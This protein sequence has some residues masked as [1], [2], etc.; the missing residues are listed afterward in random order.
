LAIP[1]MYSHAGCIRHANTQLHHQMKLHIY[2]NSGSAKQGYIL[3]ESQTLSIRTW[4][5]HGSFVF[6][7]AAP[8]CECLSYCEGWHS[9]VMFELMT[10]CFILS[11]NVLSQVQ[12][13]EP[14]PSLINPSKTLP[15]PVLSQ[16]TPLT[17][18][19]TGLGS[20]SPQGSAW[21]CWGK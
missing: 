3:L 17:V 8:R 2:L 21:N 6:Q 16:I 12:L 7:L 5:K 1:L 14:E 15:S 11:P 10:Y 4:N 18:V 13:Q 19:T 9:D 20:S